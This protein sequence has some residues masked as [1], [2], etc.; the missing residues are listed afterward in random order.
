MARSSRQKAKGFSKFLDFIGLVDSDREDEFDPE[1][2]Q[3]RSSNRGRSSRN[4]PVD[5]EFAEEPRMARASSRRERPAASQPSYAD[6]RFEEED[7]WQSGS[8]RPDYSSARTQQRQTGSSSRFA[9]RYGSEQRRGS[10]A[11]SRTSSRYFDEPQSGEGYR[12][13]YTA[14]RQ[15]ASYSTSYGTSSRWNDSENA[16]G[17]TQDMR[18]SQGG[19]YQ[20]HQTIIIHLQSVE[21]CKEVILSLIDK[22]TV[23]LNLDELDSLQTQ[24]ALDTMSGATYAIGARLSRASDRTWLIT[25]SNVE[26]AS[27]HAEESGYTGR[28]M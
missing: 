16:Y 5:D 23:L 1:F 7:A 13:G 24:R 21:G 25:P 8:S 17:S 3:P 14:Q 20:R 27:S 9:S 4:V 11:Q 12:G 2:E 6:G 28:Y 22:K 15:T 10:T 19:G 18:A 26:V